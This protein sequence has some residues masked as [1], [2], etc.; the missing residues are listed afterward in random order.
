VSEERDEATRLQTTVLRY[1]RGDEVLE[2]PWV[3]HWHTQDGFRAL[4][5][6]AGLDVAAVLA[7]TG[8]EAAPDATEFAF[9]LTRP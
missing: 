7:P 5:A 8:G 4:A 9:W 2:R 1:Q 3:L 6:A